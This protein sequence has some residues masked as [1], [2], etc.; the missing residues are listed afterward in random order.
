ML[1]RTLNRVRWLTVLTVAHHFI[2]ILKTFFQL[3]LC[4]VFCRWRITLRG[5]NGRK[6]WRYSAPI[7]EKK[8]EEKKG[9]SS[10]EF[11][12]G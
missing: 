7:P 2:E 10:L 12:A 3:N 6:K 4:F 1:K 11:D 8:K 5:A 9:S